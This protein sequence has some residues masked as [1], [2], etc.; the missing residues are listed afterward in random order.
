M[1]RDHDAERRV[2]NAGFSASGTTR[3]SVID[4][5]DE[6][7]EPVTVQG[8]RL[9]NQS[10]ADLVGLDPA[11]KEHAAFEKRVDNVA[12]AERAAEDATRGVRLR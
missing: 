8:A 2:P 12:W 5:R 7:G 9:A 11:S 3:G 10:L 1:T 4:L 6:I